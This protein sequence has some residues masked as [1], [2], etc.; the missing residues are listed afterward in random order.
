MGIG[1]TV[2]LASWNDSEYATATLSAGTFGI[3]GS[4]D[5]AT[6]ADHANPESAAT[7]SFSP[8]V[9]AMKPGA[10]SYS[11][12]YVRTLASS[13][14]G[15]VSLHQAV[16]GGTGLA[17]AL[18]FAVRSIPVETVCSD[19]V[20]SGEVGSSVVP[21]GTPVDQ[22]LESPASPLEAAGG[23]VLHYC[24]AVT[25]PVTAGNEVQ[26]ATAILTWPLVAQST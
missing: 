11:S 26:G 13:V 17:E 16:V 22:A 1:T 12:F 3:E 5:N 6:Y 18:Q 4:V 21:P 23:S 20:F 7:L 14:S 25:L 2:T 9:T 8:S 10:T 24:F 15:E 19:A